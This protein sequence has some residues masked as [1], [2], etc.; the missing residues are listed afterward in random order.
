[1]STA[2]AAYRAG[3]RAA[4]SFWLT[5]QRTGGMYNTKPTCPCTTPELRAEWQRGF[6][7]VS[8]DVLPTVDGK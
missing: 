4:V 2:T 6:A 1:M 3:R 8:A 7:K 5:Y